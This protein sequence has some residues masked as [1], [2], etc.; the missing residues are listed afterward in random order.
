MD[1]SHN[2][3]NFKSVGSD[4]IHKKIESKVHDECEDIAQ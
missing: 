3:H 4:K 1:S 2:N